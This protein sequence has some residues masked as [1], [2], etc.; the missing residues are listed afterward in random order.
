[1]RSLDIKFSKISAIMITHL[2]GDHCFGLFGLL[3][4]L[5][6]HGR[7]IPLALV[8]PEGIKEMVSTVLRLSG[9]ASKRERERERARAR[10]RATHT[11]ERERVK[12]APRGARGIAPAWGLCVRL[13]AAGKSPLLLKK[14]T[15]EDIGYTILYHELDATQA[16]DFTLDLAVGANAAERLLVHATPLAHRVPTLG[17]VFGEV[18]PL[19][20]VVDVVV[21]VLIMGTLPLYSTRMYAES[22]VVQYAYVRRVC[23]FQSIPLCNKEYIRV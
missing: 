16:H 13:R 9:G 8:G 15:G 12:E 21:V 14:Q 18:R 20:F 5:A 11:Q 1:M 7:A 6:L 3:S 2:H 10:D 4:S 17:F 19:F 22:A 23:V